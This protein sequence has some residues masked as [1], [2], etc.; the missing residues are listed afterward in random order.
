MSN[1][2][3]ASEPLAENIATVASEVAS[4]RGQTLVSPE[5]RAA[6]E[7]L[8]KHLQTFLREHNS[9]E[10]LALECTA[11]TPHAVP[12]APTACNGSVCTELST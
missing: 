5:L 1:R 7:E 9:A 11:S 8:D 10:R 4:E 3:Q 12:Y 2:V 6:L